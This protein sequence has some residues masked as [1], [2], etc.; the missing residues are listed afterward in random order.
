MADLSPTTSNVPVSDEYKV[1]WVK[2]KA[3]MRRR[4]SASYHTTDSCYNLPSSTLPGGG[5]NSSYPAKENKATNQSSVRPSSLTISSQ[6]AVDTSE[7]LDTHPSDERL[8][9]TKSEVHIPLSQP[10]SYANNSRGDT[11][12]GMKE[13]HKA[14]FSMELSNSDF[15]CSREYAHR[16][17]IEEEFRETP[18]SDDVKSSVAAMKLLYERKSSIESQKDAMN[19][20]ISEAIKPMVG[21]LPKPISRMEDYMKD[22]QAPNTTQMSQGLH[23]KKK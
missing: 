18:T 12:L 11:C 1:E 15:T 6:A 4:D 5:V 10:L 9:N 17:I 2:A 21:K 3:E 20:N 23:G 22:P 8:L 16:N 14:D 19:Y 7:H 13:L